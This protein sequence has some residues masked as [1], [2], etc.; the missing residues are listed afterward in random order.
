[1]SGIRG[2]SVADSQG[3]FV[4]TVYA[5]ATGPFIHALPLYRPFAWC[6]DLPAKN[7]ADL[8][9]QFHWAL[10]SNRSGS[11]IYAVNGSS[12]IVAEFAPDQLPSVLRSAQVAVNADPG[13]L[14]GLV[15]NADAKGARIGGAAVSADGRTLFALGDT[16]IAA[17]DIATLKVRSRILDGRS[18][19]SLRLSADGHWLYAASGG[20]GEI[21]Q[22]NPATRAVAGETNG[23]SNP[24]A[25]LWV[26]PR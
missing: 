14:G 9:Q 21:W 5:R 18:L 7:P 11:L 15:T 23:S 26:E 22:I 25:L 24:W 8:E 3:N 19:D 10:A 12:G 16:G 17:I 6:L 2:D 4:F 1:M 20:S 13:L